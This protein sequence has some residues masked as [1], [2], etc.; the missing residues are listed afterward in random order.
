MI[1][2]IPRKILD[3]YD[4]VMDKHVFGSS[5]E[6]SYYLMLS[7]F[8][9]LILIYGLVGMLNIDWISLTDVLDGVLPEGVLRTVANYLTYVESNISKTMTVAAWVLIVTSASGVVRSV[10]NIMAD[11]Q[12][13][14]RFHGIFGVGASI[15][16]AFAFIFVIY[17]SIIFIMTGEWF[18]HILDE[19]FTIDYIWMWK[20]F[21]C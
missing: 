14:G 19:H 1:K 2:K 3:V 4:I 13:K 8:P 15:V 20:W 9:A 7:I 12:G 6:M 5:A 16:I 17:L 21:L 11:I 10:I 18:L